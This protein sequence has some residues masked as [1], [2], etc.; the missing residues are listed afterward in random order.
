M[1]FLCVN[2]WPTTN[3]SQEVAGFLTDNGIKFA[4]VVANASVP[5][6]ARRFHCDL[7]KLCTAYLKSTQLSHYTKLRYFSPTP[8]IQLFLY[9][10]ELD[11]LNEYLHA[12]SHTRVKSSVLIVGSDSVAELRRSLEHSKDNLLFYVLEYSIRSL[13]WHQVLSLKSS[14]TMDKLA[15]YGDSRKVLEKYDLNG[16]SIRSISLT[17]SPY[18]ILEDCDAEG[19][20]SKDSGF[21]KGLMDLIRQDLNF[22]YVTYVEPSGDWGVIPKSGPFNTSGEWGGVMGSVVNGDFD[23]SINHYIWVLDRSELVSFA[24][25][26]PSRS[27]LTWTP[28][29]PSTDW[30]LFLRPF[31]WTSWTV[32]GAVVALIFLCQLVSFVS[33]KDLPFGND[34]QDILSTTAWYF[35][36]LLNAYYGGAMTMFFSSAPSAPFHGIRDV[37]KEYPAWKFMFPKGMELDYAVFAEKDADYRAF[38][39]RHQQNPSDTTFASIPDG[40][41]IIQRSKTVINVNEGQ[42]KAYIK[43]NL[44]FHQSLITVE[45]TNAIGSIVFTL[46][47]PLATAFTRSIEAARESGLLHQIEQRWTGGKL[48]PDGTVDKMVLTYGQLILVFV[49]MSSSL[50]LC[51]TAFIAELFYSRFLDNQI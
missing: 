28:Q 23:M 30:S 3:V 27:V 42:L 15:F 29:N 35:F 8:G 18:Y 31:T 10:P 43:S 44:S 24:A 11:Q 5:Q 26:T 2:A 25:T 39:E 21:L 20:C 47:S 33:A 34:T 9:N 17:W 14:Y 36:L 37:F 51:F 6:D 32:I 16:M 41:D 1:V 46:N 7:T 4:S 50:F 19:L 40:L 48:S 22:T 12:I 45:A 38:W 13:Q 49:I